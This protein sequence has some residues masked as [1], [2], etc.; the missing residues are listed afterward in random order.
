MQLIIEK[1]AQKGLAKMSE[2]ARGAL[3]GKLK[4]IAEN[5][6]GKHPNVK[7]L[8]GLSRHVSPAA[9]RLARD[10]SFDLDA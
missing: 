8:T 5:P 4:A 3:L 10:L 1:E 9:G 6:R 7:P 2:K